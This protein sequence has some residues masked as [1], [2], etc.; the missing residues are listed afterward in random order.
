MKSKEKALVYK[1]WFV[2]GVGRGASH[3]LIVS[4]QYD[5]L[6][7][8]YIFPEQSLERERLTLARDPYY[9]IHSTMSLVESMEDQVNAAAAP[10]HRLISE[11]E[12]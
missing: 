11:V 4:T 10:K 5:A 2:E 6:L 9:T 8:V 12:V 1:E 7:P 3:M